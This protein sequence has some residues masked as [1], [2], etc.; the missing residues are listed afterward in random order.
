MLKKRKTNKYI[1]VNIF[2][3]KRYLCRKET[4]YPQKRG[5]YKILIVVNRADTIYRYIK[6]LIRAPSW[7]RVRCMTIHGFNNNNN[8]NKKI[9][10]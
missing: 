9:I 7:W 5:I 4:T 1:P 6:I 2:I 10:L 8:N 3:H